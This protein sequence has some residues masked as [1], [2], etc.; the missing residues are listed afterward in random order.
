MILKKIKFKIKENDIMNTLWERYERCGN[1]CADYY[2]KFDEY[3]PIDIIMFNDF[4]TI[5]NIVEQ[6]I[7][8][9]EKL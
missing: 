5:A 7:L 2:E 8:N 6:A 1:L 3:V 9:N 4:E